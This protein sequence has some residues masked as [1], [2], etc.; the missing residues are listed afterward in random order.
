MTLAQESNTRGGDRLI[1]RSVA[2]TYRPTQT[3]KTLNLREYYNNSSSPRPNVMRRDRGTGF[4][5][6]SS[7]AKTTLD[8]QAARSALGLSTGMAKAQFAGRSLDD[9]GGA[10]RHVAVELSCTP[11]DVS[12]NSSP[13]EPIIYELEVRGVLDGSD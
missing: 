1:D 2:V 8:M 7:G 9:P 13:P 5:H 6:D 3:S 11:E 4:V 12:A 10:D